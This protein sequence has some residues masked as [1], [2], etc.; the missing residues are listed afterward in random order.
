MTASPAPA[1]SP[2]ETPAATATSARRTPSRRGRRRSRLWLHLTLIVIMALWLIPAFGLFVNS[3]RPSTA[4]SDS[5]WW[6]AIAPPYEFTFSNY[7]EVLTRQGLDQA[8]LNSIFITVPATVLVLA[9]AA[10]AAYA[11]AWMQFPGKNVIFV[12]VVGLLVVPLQVT[13]V[14][15]L[16]M[17]AELDIAGTFLAVWLAHTGFGL[18]IGRAHV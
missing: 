12:V 6:T 9:V 8:F 15:L 14:P 4:V 13:L 18:Q 2:T 11:F 16:R 7:T 17:F 3:F 5:G 10:F 1:A